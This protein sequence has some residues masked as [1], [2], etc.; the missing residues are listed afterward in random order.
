MEIDLRKSGMA[1]P[2]EISASTGFPPIAGAGARVLVLGT[3][4]SQA[5]LAASQY[6]AHPQNAFWKIMAE[7][8]GA[9]GDYE[10][11]QSALIAVGIAVWDVLASSVR[12][13][14]MDADIDMASAAPNDFDTLFKQ[15]PGIRLVCFNG[16]KAEQLF[17]RLVEPSISHDRYRTARLPSTSPAYASMSFEQKLSNWRGIIEPEIKK[18]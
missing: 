16:Q 4:P 6:Y 7:I 13:G 2:A 9:S 15:Y 3:L 18:G 12:P 1:S 10:T 14:S 8:A 17:T 5:S 11:R